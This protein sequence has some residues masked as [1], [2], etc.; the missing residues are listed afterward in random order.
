MNLKEQLQQTLKSLPAFACG[1]ETVDLQAGNQQLSCRLTA[2]D[3]LACSFTR[4]ALQSEMLSGKSID[5]LKSIA[6]ALASRLT[7]LLEP[8]SPIETDA[9]GCTIQMRSNP[10]SKD[11]DRTS[12]YE[13]LVAKRGEL[14]LVRFTRTAGQPREAVPAHVTR[15]VLCRLTGDLA[16]AAG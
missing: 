9:E 2:L 13:L 12:Y 15:E 5:E 8:I 7:Y 6:E 10:P 3:S 1:E 4:L 11:G 14:S 16:D